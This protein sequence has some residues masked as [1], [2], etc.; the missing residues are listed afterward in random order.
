MDHNADQAISEHEFTRKKSGQARDR[1]RK[2]FK[3]L[4]KN[5]DGKLHLKEFGKH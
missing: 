2:E 4:D 5:G 1:A 3:S